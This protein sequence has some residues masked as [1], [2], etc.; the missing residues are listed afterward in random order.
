MMPQPSAGM[1]SMSA[2]LRAGRGRGG[3]TGFPTHP[4]APAG[5]AGRVF[6]T[7][8]PLPVL[9]T[10]FVHFSPA[11]Q[12]RN[13]IYVN[14]WSKAPKMLVP[15]V[16]PRPTAGDVSGTP[17]LLLGARRCKPVVLRPAR[18]LPPPT[19][20]R[21]SPAGA[22]RH[23][24]P[25]PPLLPPLGLSPF[26]DHPSQPLLCLALLPPSPPPLN[27]PPAAMLHHA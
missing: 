5:A 19:S 6:L 24:P 18:I 4:P 17:R 14:H 23:P 7:P 13:E 21:P 8:F 16:P 12:P 9:L 26:P 22:T 10:S 1:A 11:R 27:P 20:R 3:L 25:P 2:R 15:R